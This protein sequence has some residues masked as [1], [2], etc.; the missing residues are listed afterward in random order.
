MLFVEIRKPINQ[1]IPLTTLVFTLSKPS[2]K[3]R[4]LFDNNN[5]DSYKIL[6]QQTQTMQE[7]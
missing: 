3:T 4:T 5:G 7:K 6:I 2:K 1:L